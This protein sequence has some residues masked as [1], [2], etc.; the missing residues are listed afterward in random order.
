MMQIKHMKETLL[1]P[2]TLIIRQVLHTGI[3]PDKLKIA[4]VIPVYKKDDET[5]FS[6]Y[7]PISILPAISK[8]I[9]KVVYNQIYSFFTQHKLFNESQYG[10][11]TNHSTELAALELVDRINY[12]LDKNETP[13][14]F[15]LDLSKAFDTLD[16][17]I[18]LQKL[19]YYGIRGLPL[20]LIQNYQL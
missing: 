17:T 16:H 11:R 7:R 20:N 12:T 6:N 4:K 3:C 1:E 2:I 9:E 8:I 15:F 10:F 5:I 19:N 18:L 14:S 13:F